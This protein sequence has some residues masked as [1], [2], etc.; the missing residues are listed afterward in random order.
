MSRSVRDYGKAAPGVGV[1][2][3][4]SGAGAAGNSSTLVSRR[5]W[6]SNALAPP[7]G[8]TAVVTGAF[9]PETVDDRLREELAVERTQG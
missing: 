7:D 4:G 3:D 8:R 5:F 2:A 6:M 9:R 1:R